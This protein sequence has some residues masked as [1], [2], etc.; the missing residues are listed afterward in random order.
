MNQLSVRMWKIERRRNES[1]KVKQRRTNKK[2]RE[3]GSVKAVD[4]TC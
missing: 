1:M 4:N 2:A 3:D